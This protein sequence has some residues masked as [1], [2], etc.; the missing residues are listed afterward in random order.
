MISSERYRAT[1]QITLSDIFQDY[2]DGKKEVLMKRVKIALEDL[3]IR[4][5][6]EVETNNLANLQMLL[7]KQQL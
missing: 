6:N 3:E 7:K 2:G 4:M 1:I 5:R